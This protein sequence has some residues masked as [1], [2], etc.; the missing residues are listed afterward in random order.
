MGGPFYLDLFGVTELQIKPRQRH[1]STE[2]VF[3]VK[4]GE[5]RISICDSFSFTLRHSISSPRMARKRRRASTAC[6]LFG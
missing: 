6:R 1:L 2:G 5:E 3:I 4:D